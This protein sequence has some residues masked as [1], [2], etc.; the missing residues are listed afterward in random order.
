MP[1]YRAWN[2]E[3]RKHKA[4]ITRAKNKQDWPKVIELCEDAKRYFDTIEWPD[5]W[6]WYNITYQDAQKA[7]GV[8]WTQVKELDDVR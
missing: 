7:N 1:D 6:H 8:H 2:A 3:L 4:A 5:N